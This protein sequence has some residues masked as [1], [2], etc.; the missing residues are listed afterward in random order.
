MGGGENEFMDELRAFHAGNLPRIPIMNR[1]PLDIH[2]LF[3]QVILVGGYHQ[4]VKQKA[5][6][7]IW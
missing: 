6:S 7:K 2:N 1:K 3:K 5:W 4:V